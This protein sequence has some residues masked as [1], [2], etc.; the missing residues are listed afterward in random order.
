MDVRDGELRVH[1]QAGEP[2]D[3]P[4]E[5]SGK[6]VTRIKDYDSRDSVG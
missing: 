6:E 3:R 1:D 5:P 2:P 4:Q